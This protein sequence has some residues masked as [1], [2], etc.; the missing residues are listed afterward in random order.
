[1]AYIFHFIVLAN[2]GA[3]TSWIG[4]KQ[5]LSIKSTIQNDAN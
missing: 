5:A 4:L 1:M 2:A 3:L